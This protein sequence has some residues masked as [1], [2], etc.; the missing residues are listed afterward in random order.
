M[1]LFT[2]AEKVP[3]R[4]KMYIYGET[5]TGKTVTSLHFPNPAVIDTERGT[6]YYGEFFDFHKI[7]TSD[8]DE[9]NAAIDELLKKPSGFKTLVVDPFTALYDGILEQ[10]LTKMKVKT[11]N[12][13]YTIQPLDY[14]HIKAAV[15]G[16]IQKL[17]ALDMNIIVTA[18][19][20]PL[21]SSEEFMKLIGSTADGPK[22]LP[23][24]FDVVLELAKSPEDGT[25]WAKVQKDRTNKLPDSFEFTYKSF[26]DY[27]GV[28]GLERDPVVFNQEK[29]LEKQVGRTKDIEF[30]GSQIKTAGVSGATL[31]KLEKVTA[32][33]GEDK[34]KEK[35]K[36]DYMIDSV[37][38][39]REDEAK[40]L[41][42][43]LTENQGK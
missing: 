11:G 37:L 25:F 28:D 32:S 31:A 10:Q 17:L 23:Y 1:S 9:A 15:K 4:L 2:K 5:G 41:L 21:Y 30:K 27:L 39:L 38:D 24:M 7:E 29:A 20:K 36:A 43:D 3:K 22:E 8:P 33:V 34:V 42:S 14:K 19:S 26:T 35:L 12:P 40:L 13:N 18:R 16:F 6:E